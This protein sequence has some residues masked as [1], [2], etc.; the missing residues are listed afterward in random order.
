MSDKIFVQIASYRDPELIPTIED[1]LEKA[2]NPENLVFGICW[3]Y[4]E[5]EDINRYDDN[6]SFRISKYHYSESQG[7]G[8]AR[9][10][11]NKLYGGEKYTLQIDSHHRF[12][13]H[14]DE[15]V[16]QDFN[17]ALMVSDKPII[18]TYCTPFET[19]ESPENFIQ[20]PC[21]MSQ[22]EFS[23][24]RLLMSM[25]YYIQDYK[26]LKRVIRART[27]SGHFYFTWG[28]F[29]NEV[30]YDP[31]IYFGGYTEETTMSVRAFTHGYDMFSPFRMIMWHEYTRNY[32]PKHWDDHSSESNTG[33]KSGERDILARNKTRQI[34]GQEDHGI[35]LGIFGL[36]SMRTLRQYE[37]YGGFDFSNNLIQEYTLGVN[38]PPN[39]LPW[40]G[41][42]ISTKQD[43]TVDWDLNEFANAPADQLKLITLGIIDKFGKEVFR[44]DFN[45][46]NHPDVFSGFVNSWNVRYSKNPD[47]VLVMYC[48]DKEN[49]WS[50]RYEKQL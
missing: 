22:Y 19:T 20:T 21:L 28:N 48:L 8:W 40:E 45:P 26:N 49:E 10:Q 44:Y 6:D 29:I 42:F 34:F 27:L 25:P 15:I 38:E 5:D 1:M 16:L 3:Q 50:R 32:R 33:K 37:E 13:N 31:D 47:D 23:N 39:P 18:T 14:W 30:P 24:D 36:G 46:E 41:G 4:D 9:S 11:T 2:N 35:D 43:V 7:L 12:V 17:Q